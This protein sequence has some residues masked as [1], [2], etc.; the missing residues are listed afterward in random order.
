MLLLIIVILNHGEE[1]D[2]ILIIFTFIATEKHDSN[3]FLNCI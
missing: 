3:T 2:F 1:I